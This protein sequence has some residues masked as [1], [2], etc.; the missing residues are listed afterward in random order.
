MD[1]WVD[2]WMG[3]WMAMLNYDKDHHMEGTTTENVEEKTD[4]N[5]AGQVEEGTEGGR[6]TSMQRGQAS[7]DQHN[8]ARRDT[9]QAMATTQREPEA[10]DAW[11]DVEWIR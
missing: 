4:A 9:D 5:G 1:G 2:G 7:D 3:G 8:D 10:V 6:K 11:M